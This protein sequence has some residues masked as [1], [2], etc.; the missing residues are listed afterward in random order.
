MRNFGRHTVDLRR[1]RW[2]LKA[3]RVRQQGIGPLWAWQ[4]GPLA[5]MT[6]PKRAAEGDA[7]EWE[8]LRC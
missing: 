7:T 5:G 1:R 2:R 3:L 8:D 4:A 6:W